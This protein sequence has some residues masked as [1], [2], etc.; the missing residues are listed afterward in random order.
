MII[1]V[2]RVSISIG[3][4]K[5]RYYLKNLTIEG[6]NYIDAILDM[7]AALVRIMQK[8]D[9]FN[10]EDVVLPCDKGECKKKN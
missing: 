8:L 6:D 5:G 10:E 3:Q 1:D 7:D 2:N 9:G 4:E